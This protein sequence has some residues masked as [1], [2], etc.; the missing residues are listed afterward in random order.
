MYCLQCFKSEIVLINHK[1]NCITINGTQAIKTP[2]AND[3]VHF[4]NYHKRLEVP[5]ADFEAINEKVH[6]CQLNN[7]KSYRILSE[8]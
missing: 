7:D 1:E 3:K 6:A 5:Y 4:E 8:V 2:K